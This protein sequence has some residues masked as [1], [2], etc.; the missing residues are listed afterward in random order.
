M[1]LEDVDHFKGSVK[2]EPGCLSCG[3]QHAQCVPITGNRREEHGMMV[4]VMMIGRI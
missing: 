2:V 3:K 1:W 4:M